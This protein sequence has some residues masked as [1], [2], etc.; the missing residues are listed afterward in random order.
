MQTGA[1]NVRWDLTDLYPDEATLKQDLEQA[2]AEAEAFART[3]HG[4]IDSLEAEE[5]AEALRRYEAILDR[6]GRAYTYAY[7]HWST[8]TEDPARGALLQHVRERYTQASQQL[9]FL[10]LEWAAVEPE[11]ARRLMETEALR[12]YRHY[13]E[14]QQRLRPHLLSEPEEKILAE[15]RIT[16]RDAWTRFFD[17]LL[18]SLRFELNGQLLTEQEVLA[19]LY[20]PDREVRRQAALAFTE[21]L[22]P[23]IREL[24]Y[25]FNTV[26]ADKASDDRLRGYRT[27]I[28]SRNLANEVSDEMVEA[29]IRAVT[30][31]YD[32]VARF[33]ELKRRLL[34]LDELYD[35]DRYAPLKEADTRYR[36]EEARQLVEEA[37]RAFHPRMGEIAAQFFE[38]R[39][40]DAAMTPGKRSGA[41]SHG[42]VPSAHPYILLN[43]TG[44]IRD[45]QTLAHELGHGVHQYLSRKQGLLQ[46][47]TPL[48]T[49]ETASVF[50]EM[51]VFERLLAAEADPS[52]RLAMLMGKI[53]DTMATVF[54]QVAMNRFEDRMHNARRQ[55]G[56]LPTE[57][58]CEFWIE[59]QQDMFHGSVV[60]GDHYR[61]WWS[62]IPHFI[63]TPGYVQE[64]GFTH[65][66]LLPVM[67]HPYYG[68]WGY[69]VVGYY[70]P[71]FRY[72][73][74]QD[75]MYLIDYL[76]QRGIGV[77]LDWVPSHF[78]ADPQGLVFFDGTTLFEYDDP[79]MRYHPDWGT[80]VFDYNKPGVRNFLISN[81]LFWLEK[82]HVD[83]LRVDAVAS[84]LYRD[85]SRKEWTPNIFGGRENLEA[86]DFIKR[87]NE[88]VY[89]HF[90]EAMTIAEEST[91]WP[92]VSA[93][94]YNNG[95]GFLYKW[96]M[97]WM[98]DTLDYIRR[99]PIY[100]K[101]HH[102][103]L[104]FSLW[105][106]FSEHYVLPLSHDEVVHGKGSLWGKMPGDDWQKAANLRLLFGHMWGHPGKKLLFMGGEFGQHHEWNHDTQLEWHLLDQPY[107]RGIQL[108]VRDLNHLYR[109]NPAL[110]HDG[111]E[112]F[113]WIDFSDRDQSVICYLR[114]NAG[115]MLLFVLNFTPVPR[116]HYRVGVPIGGPWR[117]V[118]NSDAVAYGGSGM[119]N[120]GRVEAV[121]ESWHGRPFHLELTLPPLA[122]L[123]LEPEHG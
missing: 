19:K 74:P 92:G 12:P 43:Y 59:T 115:R 49:A 107:H 30:E 116:E 52:N 83:G 94:T 9:L 15:K 42:A 93:P 103:E 2:L 76:H 1:E 118:L 44:T 32:L 112:G 36:W 121:P 33:Y 104:T 110:W 48:T 85:Y 78:A 66:E 55:Q 29:L 120:L 16:G 51:L 106:A 111:P 6:L 102:D 41:F 5:L 72:G 24:T 60:L 22:R 64:M 38:R 77:L 122:A 87:F 109:T 65:V 79:K 62:Y 82:Y 39:W 114:R 57:A 81:A 53:D 101:Y 3:Y 50:G 63:H 25:I 37:Y 89:L 14:L 119:G 35:Y 108:W 99:D 13:L 68:S 117:E 8:N 31:R 17:E 98:H 4:R 40:I 97:G 105:Y 71:T 11:R 113:E 73:S 54:R 86:I 7:L 95:L 88:T 23:R 61:Y 75:L 84:M 26:L 21:G 91:A 34:G 45:V 100:R 47:D 80:Y 56:E 46:A 28:E 27:W 20:D 69:Q 58:F 10:E 70:A 96:N 90:P 18:G 67:E 123:I